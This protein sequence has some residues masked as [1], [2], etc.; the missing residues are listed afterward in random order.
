MAAVYRESF[1]GGASSRRFASYVSLG[2]EGRPVHG[3]NPMTSKP[4]G[5]TVQRLIE[6]DAERIVF[7]E[8]SQLVELLG[9]TGD[10]RFHITVAT[11]GMWTDP[12]ATAAGHALSNRHPG[13]VLLW[14]GTEYDG[15]AVSAATAIQTVRCCWWAAVGAVEPSLW[16]T[17]SPRP[18]RP[19]FCL[20]TP[21]REFLATPRSDSPA[22]R[23]SD[24]QRTKRIDAS[25]RPRWEICS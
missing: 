8:A 19:R 11:P 25:P 10:A 13:E 12:A 9:W 23:G 22:P 24:M 15:A 5:A 18:P 14:F 7:D 6:L 21:R 4:V 17:T 20:A 3:Y 2:R 1:A 16:A